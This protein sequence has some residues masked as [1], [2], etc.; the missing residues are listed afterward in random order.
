M[1][2]GL[3]EAREVIVKDSCLSANAPDVTGGF[4]DSHSHEQPRFNNSFLIES[5]GVER[6]HLIIGATSV[7]DQTPSLRRQIAPAVKKSFCT[8]KRRSVSGWRYT[9]IARPGIFKPFTRDQSALQKALSP[10]GGLSWWCF[11]MPSET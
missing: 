2:S 7:Q 9:G 3:A 1:G 10:F 5:N 6:I 4:T 8:R 11:F